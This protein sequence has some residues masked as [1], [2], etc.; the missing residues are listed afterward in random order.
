[1]R[2]DHRE[3]RY[4]ECRRDAM[5]PGW[6]ARDA[7]TLKCGRPLQNR[8]ILERLLLSLNHVRIAEQAA[9]PIGCIHLRS[10]SVDWQIGR[11]R[12]QW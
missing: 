4:S 11:K 8:P 7:V 1:M 3:R 5:G 10:G 2:S 12:T 6:S 9:T